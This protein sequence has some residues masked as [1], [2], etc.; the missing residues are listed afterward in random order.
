MFYTRP[1]AQ[2][3]HQV[4]QVARKTSKRA[5]TTERVLPFL[6]TNKSIGMPG[7]RLLV[8]HVKPN[9]RRRFMS[10]EIDQEL[11]TCKT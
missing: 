9:W 6:T 4:D 2:Q 8:S 5:S 1:A 3:D 10:S 11:L 7:L